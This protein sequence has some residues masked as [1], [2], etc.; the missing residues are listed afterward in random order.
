MTLAH[1]LGIQIYSGRKFPPVEAQL[2]TIARLG[3]TN[4][5]TFGPLYDDVDSDET[6]ARCAWSQ[7]Q[8]RT[9]QRRD[10]RKPKAKGW[11]RSRDGS[12]SRSWSRPI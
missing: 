12:A 7:R 10:G 3:F 8:E 6:T 5:E 2:A 9:F 4:V 1:T 11:S